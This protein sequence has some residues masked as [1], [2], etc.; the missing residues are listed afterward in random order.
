[1]Y[2]PHHAPEMIVEKLFDETVVLVSTDRSQRLPDDNYVYIEWGPGFYARHRENY[3][4]LERPA[5]VANI[6]WLG[7][8]L[9]LAQG[10]SCYLPDRIAK[11][12]V[13]SGQLHHV[14]GAPEFSMPAYMVFPKSSESEDMQ[15]IL[16][17]IRDMA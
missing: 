15:L 4:D 7:I 9:I 3:P 17:I 11:P 6:G 1:M 8:Q 2:T 5:Q 16:E 12:L 10:G 13:A 14:K